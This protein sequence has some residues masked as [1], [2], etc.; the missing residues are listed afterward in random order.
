MAS[1]PDAERVYLD[2]HA[3]T[4]VDE[5]VVDAMQPY[6]TETYANPAS[7]SNHQ[8]GAAAN[9]AV[10]E[11]REQL[12]EVFNTRPDEFIFTSGATES[13]NLAVRGAMEAARDAGEGIHLIT[14]ATEHE[15]VIEPAEQLEKEGFDVTVV[16]V[17]AEGRVDPADIQAAIRDETALISVMAANNE[18]GTVAP[19][20]AI[21][22]IAMENDVLFHTDA[23]QAVG[24]HE[25]N[26]DELGVGLMSISGHKVYGPKGVG[27]LYVSRYNPEARVK[28]LQYGGGHERGIRSGTVNVPGVV[29]LG[30]AV[31]LAYE[32]RE[33]RIKHV[34]S[35]RDHLLDRVQNELDDVMLNGAADERLP[36]NLHLSFLG[37]D[38]QSLVR[39]KL[40]DDGIEAATGAACST[41]KT[42]SSHVLTAITDDTDRIESAVRFG[43]GKD[44]TKAEIDYAADRIVHWVSRLRQFT[45]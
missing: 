40:D 43:L 4:P 9:R 16:P 26:V 31:E 22:E 45:F 1:P 19:L 20:K 38:N 11:A 3:T 24:Y 41:L 8:S 5:R 14:A 21:G 25:L 30:K 13:D 44:N 2:H 32:E 28:P 23:V 27:A 35:L 7:N 36:N 10:T 37:V 34:E 33:E 15:A 17:D 42:E 6:F 39:T 29:G 18:I 12:A